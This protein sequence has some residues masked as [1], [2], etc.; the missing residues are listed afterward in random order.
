MGVYKLS[1]AGGLA[2]PRTNYSSFLAGNPKFSPPSYESIATATVGASSTSAT[3]TFSSISSAYTHLQLRVFARAT[4]SDSMW[5]RFNNDSGASQYDNHRLNGNGTTVGAA[6]RINYSALWVSSQGYGI[7]STAN[8]GSGIVM[9]IL[10]YQNTNKYK[11]TRT[12]SGQ[13]LNTSNS[14]IEFTSGSWKST[15]AVNRID[16]TIN[17]STFAQY[18]H[19]ALY[20]IKGA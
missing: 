1:S 18:T 10:D 19:I 15:S 17:G 2:T 8:I 20:G 14:D 16:L 4:A 7:P 5:V 12:L 3:V 13:E 9:D 11:V 6:A